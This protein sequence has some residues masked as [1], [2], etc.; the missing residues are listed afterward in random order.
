MTPEELLS[1]LELLNHSARIRRMVEFGYLAVGDVSIAALLADLEQGDFYRRWLALQSCFGSRD[2]AHALRAL[3]DSSRTI[4]ALAMKLIVLIGDD[5]QAQE[6]LDALPLNQSLLFLRR[7]FQHR[8]QEPIDAY[9]TALAERSGERLA[10][11]L[12]FGSPALVERHLEQALPSGGQA[13]WRRLARLHP[14]IAGAALLRRAGEAERLDQRLVWLANAILPTLADAQPNLALAVV[15]LLMRHVSLGHLDLQQLALRRPNEVAALVL[16]AADQAR[17]HFEPLAF[18]LDDQYLQ[19][20]VERGVLGKPGDW[21]KRLSPAQRLAAYT[22][23]QRGWRDTDGC[24]PYDVVAALPGNLR[25]QEGR[26]HLALPAL[27]TRPAQRLPYVAFL[28]WEEALAILDP[29]IRHPDPDLRCAAVSALVSLG[30]LQRER[31][32][33]LLALLHARRNEQD[34][35]RLA[36]LTGLSWLPPSRWRAEYLNDLG[37][38]IR[39]A[40]DAADLSSATASAIAR[41]IIALLPFHPNWSATWLATLVQERGRFTFS[42]LE[43]RLSDEDVRR[44]APALLPVFLSWET[45]EREAFLVTAA[46]SFGRRLSVFDALIEILERVLRQTRTPWIASRVLYS[47]AKHR[48]EQLATLIPAL[49]RED[50]SWVTQDVVYTYLHR[51]RQ[52]LI[53]PFLG[54]KAY[55]G[56]FSTG[57]TRF[58]LPLLNGFQR[59]T[60]TQQGIFAETL[61]QVTRDEKRDSPAL[62][63]VIIQLA[64]LPAVPPTR[65][66]ELAQVDNPKSAIRDL[67]LRALASLDADQGIPAL[68]EAMEDERARIAIYALRQSLLEMPASRALELLRAVPLAK[69]TVAKEVVRLLGE[70]PGKAGYADL[71]VMDGRELHRDVRVALLR[72]FWEHLEQPETWPILERAA[73]SPDPAI[74]AGVV[75]IPADR[76][77]PEAQRQL[78]GLIATL[79]GHADPKVRLDTLQRIA[80]LSLTDAEQMLL[81]PLLAAMESLLP[82]ERTAAASAVFTTYTGRDALLVGKAIERIIPHRRALDDVIQGLQTAILQNRGHLLPTAREVLKA[83]AADPLTAALRAKL[84]VFALPWDELA[85]QLTSMVASG[86]LHSEALMIAVQALQHAASRPDAAGLSS[87]ETALGGDTDERLRRLALASL[88]AL[89]QPPRGWNDERQARLRAYCADQSALVAGAAQFTFPPGEA[90]I[91]G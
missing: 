79:L 20:L 53:T 81:S 72:A 19:A 66:I 82:D 37:Q 21:F 26:R 62:G 42:T 70:L 13:D 34:P 74:A 67:A 28:P 16:G 31:L 30:R 60:P 71:L 3:G 7:L 43:E 86:E 36:M 59:W 55:R 58:V 85:E 33:D 41:L 1:E 2:G 84:A 4:R 57:K 29:F 48:H 32:P 12:P 89:A 25:E 45:R 15:R 40:L 9:L 83:L 47:V 14:A 23:A 76:L 51:H 68:L 80:Q 46:E 10:L 73:H 54:Q 52:D 49:I 8:R 63:T 38:V 35:V 17:I 87:L 39:D 88:V 65:L 90:D 27:A 61:T 44:V 75:R 24:L 56:R 91:I 5:A 22:V 64:A 50:S 78:A 77:S 6:A 18:R 69:V 11:L